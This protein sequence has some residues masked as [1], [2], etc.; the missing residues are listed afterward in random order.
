MRVN[1]D[2]PK[3]E[4]GIGLYRQQSEADMP[5]I[6][7]FAK[8]TKKEQKTNEAWPC[9]KGASFAPGITATDC[10]GASQPK[11]FATWV[12]PSRKRSARSVHKLK[13]RFK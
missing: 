8:L 5:I 11:H 10:N 12:L 13:V 9:G 4:N 7:F 6:L 2:V 1:T 3:N